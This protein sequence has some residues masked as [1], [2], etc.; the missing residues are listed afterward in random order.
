MSQ[1]KTR[2]K[3]PKNITNPPRA[4]Y[5]IESRR[6][7][8]PIAEGTFGSTKGPVLQSG[9]PRIRAGHEGAFQSR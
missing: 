4:K 9:D 5:A 8:E 6:R 3:S 7:R 2:K 1:R